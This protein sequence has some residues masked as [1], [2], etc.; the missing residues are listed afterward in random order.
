VPNKEESG[1]DIMEKVN[2]I[3]ESITKNDALMAQFK[4]DPVKAVKAVLNNLDLDDALMEQLVAA[5]KTKIDVDKAGA[6]LSG[7]KK[8]F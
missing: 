7:L 2:D 6:L 5:V 3:V 4:A 8:L 1:M